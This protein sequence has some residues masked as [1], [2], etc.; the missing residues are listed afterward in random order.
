MTTTKTLKSTTPTYSETTRI[1]DRSLDLINR[2]SYFEGFSSLLIGLRTMYASGDPEVMTPE[3]QAFCLAHPIYDVLST[4]P[5]VKQCQ[6]RPRGYSGDA[7]LID[8]F[9]RLKACPMDT[10]FRDRELFSIATSNSS[11]SSVRWRAK[12]LSELFAQTAQE[13]GRKITC[14]SVASGHIRELGYLHN[15][16]DTFEKFIA[17]D[18]DNISNDEARRSHPHPFLH[19]IDESITYIIRDGFKDQLFDFVYSA[20]LFDY[21][22]EKLAAKLIQKLYTNVSEGGALLVPNFAKGILERAYMDI[23][24]DW[25]LI[26]RSESQMMKLAD[27]AGIPQDKISLYRDPMHN[28]IYM[29]MER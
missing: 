23:F 28:V 22:N 6:S 7:D 27:M 19:I 13:K 29:R 12:H 14:L 21:L 25:K 20:G 9:Y 18:Q 24:M 8:Y 15:P 4:E 16:Q 17:L 2:E 5:T 3:Y 11:C 10:T 1:L 26:Y